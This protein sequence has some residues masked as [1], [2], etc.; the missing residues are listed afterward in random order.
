MVFAGEALAQRP[1]NGIGFVS[2]AGSGNATLP[3]GLMS[4]STD[5]Y[6][7]AVGGGRILRHTAF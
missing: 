1:L 3:S 2:T 4:S 6:N 5:W 7:Y